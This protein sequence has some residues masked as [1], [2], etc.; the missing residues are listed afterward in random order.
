MKNAIS[1]TGSPSI[2]PFNRQ[3]TRRFQVISP[4]PDKR[5]SLRYAPEKEDRGPLSKSRNACD[6]LTFAV[7][8]VTGLSA[9]SGAGNR[10]PAS[11]PAS[12]K[13]AIDPELKI[14]GDIPR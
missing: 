12:W 7:T 6:L 4:V 5:T 2:G 9:A 11:S 3:T 13:A 1:G 8:I 10:L 14:G